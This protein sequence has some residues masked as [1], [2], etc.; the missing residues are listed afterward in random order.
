VTAGLRWSNP[1][2]AHRTL[3][4]VMK[5]RYL[6][7]PAL[8][9]LLLVA[10][11]APTDTPPAKSH[12]LTTVSPR[13]MADALHAVIAANR[14]VY[15]ETIVQ[16]LSYHQRHLVC[17]Q[18]WEQAQGLPVPDQ[19]L[20]MTA[21]R[22]Q[23]QGAEFSFTLRSLWPINPSQGPQT[24]LE[25]R[26]LEHVAREPAENYYAEELLGGRSYFTAV[27]ADR[28]NLSSCVECHNA[29]PSSPRHD[30]KLGDVMGGI[31]IRVPLEF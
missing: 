18:N 7:L 4:T 31:V 28:A 22:I 1:D 21:V 15:A 16:R 10:G 3:Y 6:S 9:A 25:Q 2:E 29:H 11:D 24:A 13:K 23:K 26:G 12:K 17:Q 14:A 30:F 27:Y 19:M 5:V 8:G 20:R